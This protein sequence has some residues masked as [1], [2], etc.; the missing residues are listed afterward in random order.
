MYHVQET[1]ENTHKKM[2]IGIFRNS[3]QW[4]GGPHNRQPTI[5]PIIPRTDPPKK[6]NQKLIRNARVHSISIPGP[7]IFRDRRVFDPSSIMCRLWF[8]HASLVICESPSRPPIRPAWSHINP[9]VSS[10]D[11]KCRPSA[12]RSV[13]TTKQQQQ[14]QQRH[15]KKKK[16]TI[17]PRGR[18]SFHATE[19][20]PV[21]S[22]AINNAAPP[23]C[24]HAC[25]LSPWRMSM[26]R[27][28]CMHAY[29]PCSQPVSNRIPGRNLPCRLG[30]SLHLAYSHTRISR[31]TGPTGQL[32]Q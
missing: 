14:Q 27:S 12:A 19:D 7:N 16:K 1:T 21:P 24:H 26:A 3:S 25:G 13:M 18:E 20:S 29:M 17:G 23:R 5:L 10:C 6:I 11:S 15:T 31:R 8:P 28:T 32:S 30:A 2:H 22:E 9:C 4:G